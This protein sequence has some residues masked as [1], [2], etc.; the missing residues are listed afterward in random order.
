MSVK[1]QYS[2]LSVG[3]SVDQQ[4]GSLSVF[5][6]IEEIRVPQLPVHLQTLVM[7]VIFEKGDAL[8]FQG[9]MMIHLLTPDG[10]QQVMGSG[11]M[12][13]PPEQKRMK[14]VFRFGGFP[15]SQFGNHRF[16]LS[17]LNQ[18]GTKIAESIL[19]FDVIQ[20]TQVAQGVAPADKPH[21]P[22]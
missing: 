13:V 8:E 19:D 21:L 22:H 12:R 20:V 16:V 7:A 18:G 5:E 9:K 4:T 15:I 6:I 3:A 17:I 14:A 2:S 10:G 11:D 1:V